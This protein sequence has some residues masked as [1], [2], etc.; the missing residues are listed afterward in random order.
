LGFASGG[1]FP[2]GGTGGTDSQLVQFRASPNERVTVSGPGQSAAPGIVFSPVYNIG[3]GVSRS[4]VISACQTTQ[5]AT[6]AQMTKLIRGGA[7][8]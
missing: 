4:D 5:K 1:S 6:I 7:F 8:A 3:S 2:V